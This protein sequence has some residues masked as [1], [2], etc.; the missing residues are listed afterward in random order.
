MAEKSEKEE[1]KERV[2]QILKEIYDPEIPVN[3]YDLGLVYEVN[4]TDDKRIHVKMGVT[5]A[6][7]PVSSTI[8]AV[9]EEEL[10]SKIPEAKEVRVDI[11][12][13][14]PWDPTMVTPE[15]REQLKMIYGY[16]IVQE[17]IERQKEMQ[18]E[19]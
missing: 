7:C 8:A 3:V 11:V 13:D 9:A 19:Q 10:K 4:V 6:L 15:G 12:F 18:G 2:I 14:P 16:D 5:T 17:M 1:L